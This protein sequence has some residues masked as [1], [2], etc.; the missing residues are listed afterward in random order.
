MNQTIT[1][2]TLVEIGA[3]IMGA[4]GFYKVIMEIIKSIT[5]RHDRKNRGT[6]PS[7]RSRLTV[8]PFRM[9][10]TRGWTDRTQRFS[11]YLPCFV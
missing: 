8:K 7:R 9:S 3:I 6:R 5:A 1:L 2:Q 11:R 4:W 10:S